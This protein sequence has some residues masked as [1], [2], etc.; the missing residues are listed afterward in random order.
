[1]ENILLPSKIEFH[2]GANPNEAVFT[3][4]P[5]Y[6]GYGLTVG[7]AL[8]RVLLSSLS[9]GAITAVKIKGAD[10]EF[11]TLPYVKEDVVDI[12]LNLKKLRFNVHSDEPVRVTLKAK[13][14]V[15]VT[16]A[17]I[18]TTSDVEVTNP[19]FAVCTLTNKNAQIEMELMVQRGRGFVP[20][21][22][23]EKEKLEL[24]YIMV[25]SLF[26]PVRTVG[27]KVEDVRVGQH[28]NYNRVVLTIETDGTVS[29]QEAVTQA[30]QVLIDHFNAI[31]A[32]ATGTLKAPTP[33]VE[34]AV[35]D[36]AEFVEEEGGDESEE[37]G[38]DGAKKKR[39]RPKKGE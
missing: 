33:V 23:R 22:V 10:H 19:D 15:T 20:T 32:G 17:D 16:G 7:N 6:P 29:A 28:T 36:M 37:E 39:G 35:E 3:I 11:A 27:M 5:L 26:T 34:D 31:L 30:T 4:E 14:E 1:M 21:E 2:P 12:I 24:G 18:E 13:G 25:D 38:E 9:G 8:R